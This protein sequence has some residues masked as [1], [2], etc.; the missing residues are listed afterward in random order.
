MIDGRGSRPARSRRGRRG[1]NA[2]ECERR[3]IADRA[4][5]HTTL[6][7][8]EAEQLLAQ[9]QINEGETHNARQEALQRWRQLGPMSRQPLEL[10]AT[11][12]RRSRSREACRDQARV[13]TCTLGRSIVNTHPTSG[14][15]RA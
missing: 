1:E 4:L 6:H 2:R 5:D 10:S 12:N 15:L 11:P 8:R 9:T 13:V 3:P 7:E 14:R